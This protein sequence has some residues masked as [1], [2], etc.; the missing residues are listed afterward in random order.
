MANLNQNQIATLKFL[1]DFYSR[2]KSG[3]KTLSISTDPG[4]IKSLIDSDF[5]FHTAE[6]YFISTA[7]QEFLKNNQ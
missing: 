6:G 5:I 1:D 7:G 3:C 4:L 2:S